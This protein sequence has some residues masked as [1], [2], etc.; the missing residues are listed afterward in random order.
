MSTHYL[1]AFTYNATVLR[2]LDGDTLEV[3]VDHG[4][5]VHQTPTPVR[6]LNCNAAE[7]DTEAGAAAKAHLEALL[8]VGTPVVLSTAKPDKFAPRWD[9]D[10]TYRGADG[11][12]RDLVADLIAEQWAAPWDGKGEKPVPPWPRE[13]A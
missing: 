11:R 12:Y 13:V 8:P 7:K 5:Y 6:L 2:V 9:A 10:V 4:F 1:S 3:D